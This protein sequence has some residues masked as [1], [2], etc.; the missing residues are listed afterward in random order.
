MR[1][2][3]GRNRRNL[4]TGDP[5]PPSG[6]EPFEKYPDSQA[7]RVLTRFGG[8]QNFLQF[9]QRAGV[10]RTAMSVYHWLHEGFISGNGIRDVFQAEIVAGIQLS[11]ADW[12]P[13]TLIE[14]P[15]P[16]KREFEAPVV[17]PKRPRG[18][19]L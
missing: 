16:A 10:K 1:R 8:V 4:D 6:R 2:T 12:S 7:K 9:L 5:L 18:W 15:T 14:D 13:Y 3:R 17:P 11:D 19:V